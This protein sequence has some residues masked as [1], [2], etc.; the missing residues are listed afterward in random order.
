MNR[1]SF[2]TNNIQQLYDDDADD[3]VAKLLPPVPQ[4]FSRRA[5]AHDGRRRLTSVS[6]CAVSVVSISRR[7]SATASPLLHTT[8]LIRSQL[9]CAAP[10]SRRRS[11]VSHATVFF[12]VF[13]SSSYSLASNLFD[14]YLPCSV[15][16]R[17]RFL[18][19]STL[20]PH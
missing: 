6:R 10:T 9:E 11:T 15:L 4:N 5:R 19:V 1:E 16:D 17:A 7:I 2:S 18:S 8:N 12:P 14:S 13:S 20:A 3:V